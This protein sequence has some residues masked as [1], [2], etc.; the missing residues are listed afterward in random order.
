MIKGIVFDADG[1]LL[2]VEN[3]YLAIARGLLCEDTVISWVKEYLSGKLNYNDLVTKEQELFKSQYK[4]I[5]GDSP[6][7]G[8]LERFFYPP[9]LREG[10]DILFKSLDDMGITTYVLSTGFYYLI[11]DLYQL[12]VEKGSIYSNRLLYD[13]EGDF[14]GILTNVEG[15]KIN[16]LENILSESKL[17][18]KEMAYVGDNAFDLKLIKYMLDKGGSVFLFRQAEKDFKID[19][20]PKSKNLILIDNLKE[21]V[22]KVMEA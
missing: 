4:K 5:Y 16:G 9:R 12:D 11:K 17:D 6:K 18:I 2:E 19:E 8:D 20:L 14:M 22:N 1:T 7:T 15:D 3:P 13:T 10:A 21:I